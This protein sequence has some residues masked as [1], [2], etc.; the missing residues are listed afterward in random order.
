MTTQKQAF[1]SREAFLADQVSSSDHLANISATNFSNSLSVSYEF[2]VLFQTWTSS[3]VVLNICGN[4]AQISVCSLK[5]PG[6]FTAI[7]NILEKHKI[8]VIS[9]HVSS[10]SNQSMFMIQAHVSYLYFL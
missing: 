5:K 4:E 8:G 1:D 6:L 3:N 10:D 7:C 9:A 2:P